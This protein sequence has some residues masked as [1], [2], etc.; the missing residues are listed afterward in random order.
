MFIPYPSLERDFLSC[1]EDISARAHSAIYNRDAPKFID[2]FSG[3]S[4]L[5]LQTVGSDPAT[6]HFTQLGHALALLKDSTSFQTFFA[7]HPWLIFSAQG[8]Y[9]TRS[10]R[11]ATLETRFNIGVDY[12]HIAQECDIPPFDSQSFRRELLH[13]L[14]SRTA[15]VV[16]GSERI[17]VTDPHSHTLYRLNSRMHPAGLFYHG[18]STVLVKT[19]LVTERGF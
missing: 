19:G 13:H 2:A 4:S 3:Y 10:D 16:I 1:A 9:F 18:D 17:I 8:P 14:D 12:A 7:Q 11:R 5:F 6:N 15:P